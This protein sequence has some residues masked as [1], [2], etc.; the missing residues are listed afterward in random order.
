MARCDCADSNAAADTPLGLNDVLKVL[1]G[2]GIDKSP[3]RTDWSMDNNLPVHQRDYGVFNAYVI[4]HAKTLA[5]QG[6]VWTGDV[7]EYLAHLSTCCVFRNLL[8]QRHQSLQDIQ[9]DNIMKR[10]ATIWTTS[11]INAYHEAHGHSNLQLHFLDN[12]RLVSRTMVHNP[13][14]HYSP[15]RFPSDGGIMGDCKPNVTIRDTVTP[16][17]ALA[18]APRDNGSF[19]ITHFTVA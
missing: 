5:D 1:A 8:S 16:F 18:L 2:K 10:D 13:D 11:D 3:Q 15:R 14:L 4:W 7:L 12:G 6:P 9:D 19:D 17:S